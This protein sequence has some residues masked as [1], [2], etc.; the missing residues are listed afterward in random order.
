MGGRGAVSTS[1]QG[2]KYDT[3]RG[4]KN[5]L[6]ALPSIEKCISKHPKVAEGDEEALRQLRGLRSGDDL[7][8]IY[9]AAPADHIN[10]N[11]WVFLSESKADRFAHQTFDPT[12]MKAGYKVLNVQVK[13]SDVMWTGKNLEFAYVGKRRKGI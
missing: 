13:A 12:K 8:T 4:E 7:V 1:Y 6:E 2:T 3:A 10:T 11:D 5:A 9:R